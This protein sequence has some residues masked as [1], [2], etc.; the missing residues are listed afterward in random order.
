MIG[1]AGLTVVNPGLLRFLDGAAGE[2]EAEQGLSAHL[3][4][5]EAKIRQI[6]SA[7]RVLPGPE[8]A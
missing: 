8:A 2:I 7:V 5:S 6:T 1:A 4:V 3:L